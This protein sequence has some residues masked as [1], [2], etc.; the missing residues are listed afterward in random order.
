MVADTLL[1]TLEESSPSSSNDESDTGGSATGDANNFA[2]GCWAGFS[3]SREGGV[4]LTDSSFRDLCL[5]LSDFFDGE[6]VLDFLTGDADFDPDFDFDP[7]ALAEGLVAEGDTARFDVDDLEESTETAGSVW[8]V[9][10]V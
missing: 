5:V 7:E 3:A 10:A 4:T 9:E 6:E 8:A 1:P 2:G